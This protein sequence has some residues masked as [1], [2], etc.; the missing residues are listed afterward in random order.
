MSHWQHGKL[1]IKCELAVLRRA[2][3]NIVPAWEKHIKVDE[4]GSLVLKSGYGQPDQPG[5]SLLVPNGTAGVRGADLG[6][7]RNAD[8]TW[9]IAHDYVPDQLRNPEGQIAQEIANMKVRAIAKLKR[10]EI[11]KDTDIGNE[12]IIQ[13]AVPE[14][15]EVMI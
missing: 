10:L 11:V 2:L 6:F 5:Y 3:I 9:S 4:S 13:I 12:H 14:T 8:G 7:K 1:S 15:M